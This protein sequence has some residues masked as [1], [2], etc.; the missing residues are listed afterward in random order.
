[1]NR[2]LIP[3]AVAAAMAI[4]GVVVGA[5]ADGFPSAANAGAPAATVAASPAAGCPIAP[6]TATTTST[7][8]AANG[9]RV[10]ES[11]PAVDT[12]RAPAAV[13]TDA[14]SPLQ[15]AE[16]WRADVARWFGETTR[17]VTIEYTYPEDVESEPAHQP[18]SASRRSGEA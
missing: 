14:E 5:N 16:R 13:A 3:T 2:L 6:G 7:I 17:N 18:Y 15:I 9:Q 11:V 10:A 4:G 8:P 1:M 12:G